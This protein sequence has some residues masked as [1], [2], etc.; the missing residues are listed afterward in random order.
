M[1]FWLVFALTGYWF[2]FFKLQEGVYC[3]MPGLNTHSVNYT[4]YDG[5]F[6]A[7]WGTKVAF[8]FFKIYFEQC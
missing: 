6:G 3:F 1:F 5:V 7:V 8:M 4:P 2:V